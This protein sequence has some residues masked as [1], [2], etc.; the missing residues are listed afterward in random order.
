GHGHGPGR[1]ERAVRRRTRAWPR[2][3]SVHGPCRASGGGAVASVWRAP[4]ALGAAAAAA[5][6][7][8]LFSFLYGRDAG[9]PELAARRAVAGAARRAVDRARRPVVSDRRWQRAGVDGL[10]VAP[11]AARPVGAIDDRAHP[12]GGGAGDRSAS[13][14]RPAALARLSGRFS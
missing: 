2:A 14:G 4:Q 9:R 1:R 13:R 5:R 7:D 10:L 3:L 6:D 11:A 12:A 8:V